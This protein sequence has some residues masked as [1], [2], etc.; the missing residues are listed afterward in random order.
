MLFTSTA[1]TTVQQTYREAISAAADARKNDA[2]KRLSFYHDEQT[3][4][5]ND[6]LRKHFLKPENMTPCFVN[7]VKKVINNRLV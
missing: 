2:L 1:Q 6:E 7:V 3:S 5:I 4:Y